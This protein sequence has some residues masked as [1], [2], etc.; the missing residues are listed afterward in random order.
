RFGPFL[1]PVE[2]NSPQ[3]DAMEAAGL[4]VI[5]KS[6]LNEMGY[7]P[8]T[9]PL[10]TGPTRNPWDLDRCPGGSSGGAA[11]AV[12]AGVV[13]MADA[14]DGGG[15]IRIPASACG[16]FGL[17]PSRDRL[18]GTQELA[19]GYSLTAEH[20]VSRSVRD[21]AG[22]F[23]AMER[24]GSDAVLAPV[25]DVNG[26]STHRLRIG[27]LTESLSGREPDAEVA[28]ALG[29]A[30]TLLEQLGHHVEATKLPFDGA[31]V[32]QNF[33]VIWTASAL[34]VVNL[35]RSILGAEPNE[36][37]LE[38]FTLSM[39]QFAAALPD[40]AV[41][42]AKADLTALGPEYERWFSDHDVIL[43]PVL[44]TPPVPIGYIDGGVSL[45]ALVERVTAFSDYT[46]L[47]NAVGAPAMSVPLWW[48]A[49]GLPIGSH[50]AARM[51]DERTLFEL[52]YELEE[53]Q[54]WRDRWPPVVAG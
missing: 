10:I 18:V 16:L 41:N 28:A 1:P 12:A 36:T 25:G 33:L 30:A 47:H 29:A 7:L 14:A 54:P 22:L 34:Q 11:A 50:F 35:V 23:A 19:A 32:M 2:A 6:A 37:V 21:S 42:E 3:V 26:P 45:D 31:A 15:S 8:T 27:L 43:S 52:A 24:V 44:L 9:E 17:K 46:P 53:A 51:G 20:C 48:T 4:I 38:P 40:G 49:E 13:P 39:A 5:G